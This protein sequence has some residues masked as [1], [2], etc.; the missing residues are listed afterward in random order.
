[1][2]MGERQVVC[3][4]QAVIL[5]GGLGARLRPITDNLPKPMVMVNGK[6][7]LCH[8]LEQLSEQ[9]ITR[10]VLLTGYLGEQ[11]SDYFGDGSQYGWSISY[12]R[13]PI[14]WDTGRRVWEARS[15]FD[16]QFLLL[17]SDNFVQ[18]NLQKL[19]RLH[20]ELRTPI[21]LLLAPKAKG[22]IKVSEQGRIQAYDKTRSGVGFDYVEVGYM[23][24]ERDEILRE[25]PLFTG[26]PD[27]N[28]SALLQKL[29]WQQK[30]AGLV[31][32]D[33]YRSI[34]DPDRLELMR[35]YLKPKRILLIDRDG[36]INQKAPRGEYI[37]TWEEFKWI[38]EMRQAMKELATR[39]FKFIVIT[40]QAG[41]AR[42]MVNT[43]ELDRIHQ[44]MISELRK[45]GIEILGVYT[46][47]H[48]WDDNCECRKPKPEMFFQISAKHLLRMDQ[49]IFVGDD[50]R[51]R[52]AAFN[53][54]CGSLL[55]GQPEEAEHPGKTPKWTMNAHKFSDAVPAIESFFG[56][57]KA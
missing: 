12:S 2:E 53:A 47:P 45:E 43:M 25:F 42:G 10:F 55:I 1:M 51:D 30:I 29:S 49:T 20:E 32:R 38:P 56:S 6:P 39:G 7:F 31:V 41:V 40:N 13:G 34:S 33:S 21:S 57:I 16:A 46:C 24:I 3:P 35:S 18:F 4:K 22:N 54:G 19:K 9:S 11:I 28:F 48:H 26:F 36:V 8:L 44:L 27:F 14:E 5:C 15:Q 50:L 52:E 37:S 17:Y 23:V